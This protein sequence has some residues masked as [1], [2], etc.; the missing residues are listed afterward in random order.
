M[1]GFFQRPTLVTFIILLLV[2]SS[3]SMLYAAPEDFEVR[4]VVELFNSDAP[5]K[6][7][8]VPYSRK[9][10]STVPSRFF[11]DRVMRRIAVRMTSQ[12]YRS[13]KCE[14]DVTIYLPDGQLPQESQGTAAIIL[15]GN[16][17]QVQDAKL[18]W[19]ETTVLGLN[20]PCVVVEQAFNA[21]RFGA[22]NPGELMSFGS[23]RHMETGDPREAG[24]YAL[25]KIFSAAATV[26]EDL[27]EVRA[28][29]FVVTGSSK[30]GMAALIACAGDQRIVGAFP[31]AWNSGDLLAF[32]RLKG[33]RWGWSVK[34]KQ[35]GPAGQTARQSM[36]M[37]DS[38]HGRRYRELFDPAEWGDLLKGKFIMPAVGTNDP[39]FHLLSDANYFDAMKCRRAF[40]RVPNYPH[41]RKHARHALGWR[42]AVAAALLGRTIPSVQLVSTTEGDHVTLT[43]QL[44]NG[45]QNARLVLWQTTDPDGDYRKARWVPL[46]PIELN[47]K[48]D[49]VR[50]ARIAVPD[51]GTAAFFLQL[52]DSSS[53]PAFINSS[54]VVELGTPDEHER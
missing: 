41:G 47:G 3:R 51:S 49:Q 37:L 38:P 20:V 10:S 34:P 42:T 21:S 40:L 45:I 36:T 33:R 14:H 46:P 32:T 50:V 11:T 2:V 30:G 13:Q 22:R 53:K 9:E 43:A 6:T 28:K 23:R 17:I 5:L 16:A 4:S 26:A 27:P 7:S 29:R 18:D 52:T 19:L 48:S 44:G 24:Y 1:A 31:T 25:A 39:L 12:T 54:N 35:T 15:G 8:Q